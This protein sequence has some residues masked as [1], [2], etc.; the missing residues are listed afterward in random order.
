MIL[1]PSF[2]TNNQQLSIKNGHIEGK[3]NSNLI[4]QFS[5]NRRSKTEYILINRSTTCLH[6]LLVMFNLR[7]VYFK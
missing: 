6:H 7:I 5:D 1:T 2:L 3:G 4:G